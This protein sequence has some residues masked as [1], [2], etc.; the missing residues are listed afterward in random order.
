MEFKDFEDAQTR[1]SKLLL[2]PYKGLAPGSVLGEHHTAS[3][4]QTHS[5]IAY[6]HILH[7]DPQLEVL[8]EWNVCPECG[9]R[10]QKVTVL[11]TAGRRSYVKYFMRHGQYKA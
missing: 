4:G 1:V 7:K 11:D 9:L 10:N 3:D 5:L 2:F 6:T 8:A